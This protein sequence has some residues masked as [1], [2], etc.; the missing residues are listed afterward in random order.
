MYNGT[1]SSLPCHA[2]DEPTIHPESSIFTLS[3]GEV[4]TVE[5]SNAKSNVHIQSHT[6]KKRS[7]YSMTRKCQDFFK[8]EI[9]Q[10]SVQS[11]KE[12]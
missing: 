2:D 6:C 11:L 3:I 12:K 7:L 8:H 4:C 9:K 5:F 1:S 10:G